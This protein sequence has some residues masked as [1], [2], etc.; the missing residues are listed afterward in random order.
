MI[1]EHFQAMWQERLMYLEQRIY[2]LPDQSD[3]TSKW[4]GMLLFRIH[5][6]P[7]KHYKGSW[8]LRR[9]LV[10]GV[11]EEKVLSRLFG[12]FPLD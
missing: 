12:F 2:Q 7:S 11:A 9:R 3:N 4:R 5:S 8:S 1:A 6:L 10:W